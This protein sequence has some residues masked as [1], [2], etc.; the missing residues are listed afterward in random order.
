MSEATRHERL[1][2]ELASS[3]RPVRRL[4][5]PW[6][7]AAG[8][9]ALVIAIGIGL[10]ALAGFD[11]VRHRLGSS[12]D[13]WLAVL[14]SVLTAPLAA[15]AAFQTSVPGRSPRWALLPLPT[16]L[17]WMAASGVE[18]I[19]PPVCARHRSRPVFASTATRSPPIDGT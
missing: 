11:I 13:A 18:K 16:A 2:G 10:V 7:R 8:W 14:G 4:P 3:L 19:A 9:V 17:L 12:P 6:Q 15:F 5:P 1:I